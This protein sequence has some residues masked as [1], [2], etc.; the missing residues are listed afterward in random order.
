MK[1]IV[2][3][4]NYWQ[5]TYIF[6]PK[7]D[8]F[9]SPSYKNSP[10]EVNV[11][12]NNC[13]K[14]IQRFD[15]DIILLQEINPFTLYEINYDKNNKNQYELIHENKKII[16]HE[17]HDELYGE[18]LKENFWGNAILINNFG[19]S[20]GRSNIILGDSNYYGRN[21]LMCYDFVS[22]NKTYFTIINYYNKKN[23]N[24]NKYTMPNE[25][26][27]DLEKI[28][29]EKSENII[30]FAGDFNSDKE[31]DAN[32][33][34]FFVFLEKLGFENFTKDEE[35]RNTMV[36]EAKQYPNDKVFVI[37]NSKLK[38]IQ[39]KLLKETNINLSDHYP[40]LC[41]CDENDINKNKKIFSKITFK[42]SEQ[43]Q[44]DFLNGKDV[45]GMVEF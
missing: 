28:V 14:Y 12:I 38:N 25:I 3:N 40:I 27:N 1:I 35:F 21:G 17:L 8:R 33:R 42:L 36:P 43:D 30:L 7:T 19:I 20:C 31:K 18:K 11:W 26:K 41:E 22:S 39:C 34:S 24:E 37:N 4:M 2:W 6:D 5:N 15:A 10:E 44:V 16:Y 9:K 13:K 23:R 45:P 29:K 32:N